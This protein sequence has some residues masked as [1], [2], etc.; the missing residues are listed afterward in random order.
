[1]RHFSWTSGACK[2]IAKSSVTIHVLGSFKIV[3]V[4]SSMPKERTCR[5]GLSSACAVDRFPGLCSERGEDAR[6]VLQHFQ[7]QYLTVAE[8]GR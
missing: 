7:T 3:D 6:A 5:S 2:H 8:E 4:E 1:M